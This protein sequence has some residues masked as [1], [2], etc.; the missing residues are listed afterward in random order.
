MN[1]A[2]LTG[3]KLKQDR[4]LVFTPDRMHSKH[5]HRPVSDKPVS[6]QLHSPTLSYP[7]PWWQRHTPT[8]RETAGDDARQLEAEH[9]DQRQPRAAPAPRRK[10]GAEGR[11]RGQ[12]VP[13]SPRGGAAAGP[14]RCGGAPGPRRSP[15]GRWVP[16]IP[17]GGIG[18]P[19]AE[20]ER[21]Q[22]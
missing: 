18:C 2:F 11:G 22:T 8:E 4:A 21:G 3:Q 9:D 13:R 6:T 17:R 15:A 12:A 7:S 10:V 1:L 20:A 16:G 19:G 5:R 14:G